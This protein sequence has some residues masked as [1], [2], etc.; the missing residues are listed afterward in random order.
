MPSVHCSYFFVCLFQ[1]VFESSTQLAGW[2]STG[3][4]S[5]GEQTYFAIQIQAS[6]GSSK[7]VLAVD[8]IEFAEQ[9]A[10][11]KS[12]EVSCGLSF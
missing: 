12:M 7:G 2:Q 9:C 10:I 5:I 11:G 6:F 1:V 3:E 4:I 8:D